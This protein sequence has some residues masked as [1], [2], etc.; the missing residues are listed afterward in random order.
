MIWVEPVV[1]VLAIINIVLGIRL[2]IA[3]SRIG[4]RWDEVNKKWGE[5]NEFL[6][7]LRRD[8]SH[9][10]SRQEWGNN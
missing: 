5:V 6:A 2:G 9:A 3:Y 10:K 7:Q 4:K 1:W 8:N